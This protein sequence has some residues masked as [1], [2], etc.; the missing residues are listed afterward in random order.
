MP[1]KPDQANT[2]VPIS[3]H[4]RSIFVYTE[5][6]LVLLVTTTRHIDDLVMIWYR[7]FR[8]LSVVSHENWWLTHANC[9]MLFK[10]VLL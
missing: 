6:R 3:Q 1:V 7:R 2:T 8:R 10:W 9:W 5:T 4:V